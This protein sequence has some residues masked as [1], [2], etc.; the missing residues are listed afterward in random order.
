MQ[1]DRYDIATPLNVLRTTW[2]TLEMVEDDWKWQERLVSVLREPL[3]L[4]KVH[5]IS[6]QSFRVFATLDLPPPCDRRP[7]H[8]NS[9]YPPSLPKVPFVAKKAFLCRT[10]GLLF[11]WHSFSSSFL[12]IKDSCTEPCN[13]ANK[14]LDNSWIKRHSLAFTGGAFNV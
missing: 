4:D 6:I 5:S 1:R 13:E 9:L 3:I 7:F 8:F 12:Y 10:S 2:K 11:F 14:L